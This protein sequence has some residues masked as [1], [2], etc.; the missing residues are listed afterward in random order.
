MPSD[1]RTRA[2]LRLLRDH[3][4]G[5]IVTHWSAFGHELDSALLRE[6]VTREEICGYRSF[7]PAGL[8]AAR[9]A[10]EGEFPQPRRNP[11]GKPCGECHVKPGETCDICGAI[12]QED[13]PH[14]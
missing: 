4:N 7:T 12:A 14:D 6:G 3:D 5:H 11:G 9:A 8:A 1:P 13:A 2:L 10:K